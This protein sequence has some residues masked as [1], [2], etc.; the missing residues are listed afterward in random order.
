MFALILEVMRR[1]NS[2]LNMVQLFI[3]GWVLMACAYSFEI[4]S[5]S[6]F[7]RKISS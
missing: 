4:R 3:S 1:T 5:G 2:M 7:G 6:G